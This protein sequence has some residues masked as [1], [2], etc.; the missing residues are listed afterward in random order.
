MAPA[1][2][3]SAS[4]AATR[5]QAE[6]EPPGGGAGGAGRSVWNGGIRRPLFR[7]GMSRKVGPL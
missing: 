4:A 2:T 6:T 7:R 1:R 5:S 3:T